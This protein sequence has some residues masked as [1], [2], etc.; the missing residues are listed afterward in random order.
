MCPASV[1]KIYKFFTYFYANLSSPIN[2]RN[3]WFKISLTKKVAA[4][5]Y[6]RNSRQ[7]KVANWYST[8]EIYWYQV[9]KQRKA[10]TQDYQ[11]DIGPNDTLLPALNCT[12]QYLPFLS[13]YL[14]PSPL[15]S[16]FSIR[17]SWNTV[18]VKLWC[19]EVVGNILKRHILKLQIPFCKY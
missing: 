1:Y 11:L 13:I 17:Y 3:S 14:R 15:K 4:N 2:F 7:N 9:D 5:V 18:I 6:G 10:R 16:R 19:I 8:G 12:I